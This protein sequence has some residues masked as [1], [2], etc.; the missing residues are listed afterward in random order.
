MPSRL[1][2]D[3]SRDGSTIPNSKQGFRDFLISKT[4]RVPNGPQ[5]FTSN[6]YVYRTQSQYANMDLGDVTTNEKFKL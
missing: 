4:L 5:T 1:D 3:S 6:N 2:F